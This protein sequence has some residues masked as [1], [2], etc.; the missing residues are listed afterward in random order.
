M[1]AEQ[2][3]PIAPS[4]STPRTQTLA[5]PRLWQTLSLCNG[6]S[7]TGL[8]VEVSADGVSS[9]W[10]LT[11]H[12]VFEL[13]LVFEITP[14]GKALDPRP[15]RSMEEAAALELGME[16]ERHGWEVSVRD[17]GASARDRSIVPWRVRLG[18]KT[19]A[20]VEISGGGW[21]SSR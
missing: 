10:H 14:A 8:A 19:T 5:V 12:A 21:R 18:L 1:R 9:T 16:L 17:R 13:E 11:G 20:M 6:W 15:G 2:M 7:V 3:A 4:S